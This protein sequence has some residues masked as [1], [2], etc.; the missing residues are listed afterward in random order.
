MNI[1]LNS[2][3]LF[4]H[5]MSSAE[6][7]SMRS[8]NRMQYAGSGFVEMGRSGSAASSRYVDDGIWM[9][10]N[11]SAPNV[12]ILG[13]ADSNG[14]QNTNSATKTP[15]VHID[16]ALVEIR[17]SGDIY[18]ENIIVFPDAPD[19]RTTYDTSNLARVQH[20]D[21]ATAFASE[22]STNKVIL[23]RSDLVG[24]EFWYEKLDTNDV[25]YPL[26]NV[27]YAPAVYKGITLLDNL[28]AT[29]YSGKLSGY[30]VDAGFGMRWS[31]STD[32]QKREFLQDS[33]NNIFYDDQGTFIQLRYRIRVIEGT[34]SDWYKLDS[35][36]PDGNANS[37]GTVSGRALQAQGLRSTVA[38]SV[39][40][41]D[42]TL[43]YTYDHPSSHK[44]LGTLGNSSSLCT[45][46]DSCCF[47]QIALV[48]RRNSGAYHPDYNPNGSADFHE[49]GVAWHKW[50]ED[51]STWKTVTSTVDCFTGMLS[52]PGLHASI[53]HGSDGLG[54]PDDKYFDI[55]YPEDVQDRR[56]SA[57]KVTDYKR[58]LDKYWNKALDGTLRG[59]GRN[60]RMRT[61]AETVTVSSV[62]TYTP[63]NY[64]GSLSFATSASTNPRD[65]NTQPL[66]NKGS[67]AWVLMGSN[68]EVMTIPRY[69]GS[70][71]IYWPH[72][73][74]SAYVYGIGDYNDPTVE[75]NAKF[76]IG[77]VISIGALVQDNMTPGDTFLACDVIGDPSRFPARWL[78]TGLPG[79]LTSIPPSSVVLQNYILRNKAIG[80]PLLMV[81]TGD[82]G[83]TWSDLTSVWAS[84]YSE[85]INGYFEDISPTDVVLVFYE[86]KAPMFNDT[87]TA[88]HMLA[89]GS[90]S[91][92]DASSITTGGAVVSEALGR[93]S[94][95]SDSINIQ[96]EENEISSVDFADYIKHSVFTSISGD[97]SASGSASKFFPRLDTS[98]RRA[99]RALMYEEVKAGV[100]DRGDFS[101]SS[102]LR[103][104]TNLVNNNSD[105]ID[106]GSMATT[107]PFFINGGE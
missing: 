81:Y 95:G 62:G 76:P 23:C 84:A 17:D 13:N 57:R 19:G 11:A 6:F 41:D 71:S 97:G 59:L 27:Q 58:L 92:I 36:I 35:I 8:S 98:S 31:T 87:W 47:M 82:F 60:L 22:T 66:Y 5:S 105:R 107:L 68:R 1:S 20:A 10:Y 16:G 34:D 78:T 85:T 45:D 70:D 29:T 42:G 64:G 77:T 75:F 74:N 88:T 49:A 80:T 25:V 54:R 33:R 50:Y 93:H 30:G 103:R 86:A 101:P 28:L 51:F 9:W 83:A 61:I 2:V 37:V 106:R 44:V 91:F 26:G 18:Q 48:A 96:L 46:Y 15:I 99:K 90:P 14:D 24:L 102:S 4:S 38:N 43:M 67:V 7:E 63:S 53:N 40:V 39:T 56:M 89:Y 65:T 21:P 100:D 52:I 94:S 12:I 73:S 69:G 104:L 55:I 79:P 3:D 32:D 72:A